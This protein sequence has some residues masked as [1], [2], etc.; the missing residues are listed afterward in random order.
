MQKFVANGS[1][2]F[3]LFDPAFERVISTA[4]FGWSINSESLINAPVFIANALF[5]TIG[6]DGFHFSDGNTQEVLI[7]VQANTEDPLSSVLDNT[8]VIDQS[9]GPVVQLPYYEQQHFDVILKKYSNELERGT[10]SIPIEA[11]EILD[12]LRNLSRNGMALLCCS[13]GFSDLRY[14]AL[15]EQLQYQDLSFPLN[16][17]ALKKY[18]ATI[19]GELFVSRDP[20]G[21]LVSRSLSFGFYLPGTRAPASQRVREQFPEYANRLNQVTEAVQQKLSRRLSNLSCN[22]STIDYVVDVVTTGCFDPPR[23][24]NCIAQMMDAI[25]AELPNASESDVARLKEVLRKVDAN[26]YTFDRPIP[27]SIDDDDVFAFL[28]RIGKGLLQPTTNQ[29]VVY[30]SPSMNEIVSWL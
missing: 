23:F 20:L 29:P 8:L 12:N 6:V 16:F 5:D 18:F 17:D 27:E 28:I 4:C 25:E 30:C 9:V 7:S 15:A 10:L 11:L 19:G 24:V 26:I 21:T 3:A 2:D 22:Q 14:A 13:R 1:L